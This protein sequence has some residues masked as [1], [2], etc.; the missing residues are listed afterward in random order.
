MGRWFRWRALFVALVAVLA[1]W[2]YVRERVETR[3]LR[4]P[5]FG[6]PDPP[7]LAPLEAT[8]GAHALAGRVRTSAGAALA[9]ASVV[10]REGQMPRSTQTDREGAFRF[11]GLRAGT[12]EVAVLAFGQTPQT[13]R[14]TLP[15]EEPLEL[16]LAAP[17][18]PLDTLPAITRAPLR[19]R[20]RTVSAALD[21]LEVWLE[22]APG[23]DPLTGVVPRRARVG[24]D[25]A[26][27]LDALAA[28]AYSLR[29]LPAW[30]SGG[31]WPIVVQRDLEWSGAAADLAG[32]LE[33]DYRPA[34]T[35]LRV[36]DV[37]GR[38]MP[39]ALVLLRERT[40][41]DRPLHVWPARE[42]DAAGEVGF[43]DLP[44]GDYEIEIAAGSARK[45]LDP[46][47]IGA[48]ERKALG[49][50]VLTP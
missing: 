33:L 17:R 8:D 39:G 31:S 6:D 12:H 19:G 43:D 14:V 24:A 35:A 30:A 18:A 23:T 4:N 47:R 36:L 29:V 16:A 15:S 21:G 7:V 40:A 44:G 1:V 9:D 5:I 45:T 42:S 38:A 13:F 20:L 34:T 26:F 25:G 32:G 28:G 22:P 3:G 11:E 46:F 2:M 50:V 41:P 27:E 48:G 49:D 10:V 37:A